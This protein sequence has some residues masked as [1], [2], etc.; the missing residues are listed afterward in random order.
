MTHYNH[1]MYHIPENFAKPSYLCI[2]EIA[3]G[4]KF[5]RCGND[6]YET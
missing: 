3:G 1:Y 6:H 5:H 4:M 2:I